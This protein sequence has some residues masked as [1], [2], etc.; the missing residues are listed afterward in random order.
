M[1]SV[2][3]IALHNYKNLV[4]E[5]AIPLENLTIL[6]GPNASGKSN[7]IQLLQF[8]SACTRERQDVR[9][10]INSF[11]QAVLAL[12][13]DSILDQDIILSQGPM[14][15]GAAVNLV[16][17]FPDANGGNPIFLEIELLVRGQNRKVIINKE[18]LYQFPKNDSTPFYFYQA[19]NQRGDSSVVLVRDH[20]GSTK[21]NF[22]PI[23][24]IPTDELALVALPR[25]LESSNF[26]PALAP[27]YPVRRKILDS[28]ST[29]Q[30]Y[31]ANHMNLQA[32]RTA[33]PKLGLGDIVLSPS[34]ENLA[35]VFE[36]LSS[37]LDFEDAVDEAMKEI[38][39]WTHKVRALRSGFSVIIEWS[40]EPPGGKR[41]Q[42]FLKDLSDGSV[43]MLCWAVILC[44]PK[45]PE[46][47][48]IEE[49]EIGIHPAWM[50]ML[51]RWIKKAA[52]KTQVIIS[53]HSPD[54]LDHFTDVAEHVLVAKSV[55]SQ[56][57]QFAFVPL[58][59][60][61]IAPRLAEGWQL[62]D[63]YRVGDPGVGGWPW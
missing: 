41:N 23:Q 60:A 50:P 53:T 2:L 55:T 58:K 37:D 16:Y 32:I 21:M 52:Q 33:T 38:L 1:R 51:A 14:Q 47:L 59:Q 30:F 24:G 8:L 15:E 40:F 61:V 36:N 48:V 27:V 6:I 49:P 46:L 4:V 22:Q 12:G 34:G 7:L 31:N 44:S 28:L 20:P 57:H 11:T 63:L 29:W 9:S 43:R 39:P 17:E 45:L 19:H 35:I 62:G 3:S 25:S 10:S 54:L 56:A 5:K 18:L 42:F 13:G 26:S